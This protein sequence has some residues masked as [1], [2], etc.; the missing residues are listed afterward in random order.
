MEADVPGFMLTIAGL[1][2]LC[3]YMGGH[4]GVGMGQGFT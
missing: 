2:I 4:L 1:C 3:F